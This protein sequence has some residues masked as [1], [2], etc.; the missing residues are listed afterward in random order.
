M[1]HRDG[2][3]PQAVEALSRLPTESTVK[4]EMADDFLTL[5]AD[6]NPPP[7]IVACFER[8]LIDMPPGHKVIE[9]EVIAPVAKEAFITPRNFE[10]N[11]LFMNTARTW[12]NMSDGLAKRK[13]LDQYG[14]P[15]H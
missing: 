12:Q 15:L 14:I 7:K 2:L 4:T 5:S 10:K 9:S 8:D 6:H 1:K 13:N 11:S 3:V